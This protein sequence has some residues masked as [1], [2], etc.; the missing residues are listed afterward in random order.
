MI[1]ARLKITT[2]FYKFVGIFAGFDADNFDVDFFV[3]EI[4]E[5][6]EGRIDSGIIRIKTEINPMTEAL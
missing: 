1:D 5:A 2:R 6:R 3:E 4:F